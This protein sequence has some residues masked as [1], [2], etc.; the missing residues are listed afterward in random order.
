MILL[1]D[2]K[3]MDSL[4]FPLNAAL[5]SKSI[6]QMKDQLQENNDEII[7]LSEEEPQYLIE[8][9]PSRINFFNVIEKATKRKKLMD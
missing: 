5:N 7:D 1:I 2:G 9:V 4:S 3:E 8:G 6:A